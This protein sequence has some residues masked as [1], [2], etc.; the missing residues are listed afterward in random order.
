L[1][2][3]ADAVS[4]QSRTVRELRAKVSDEVNQALKAVRQPLVARTAAALRE[5]QEV[6]VEDAKVLSS[7]AYADV[8]SATVGSIGFAPVSAWGSDQAWLNERRAQGYSV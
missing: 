7:L 2:V 5:L 3:V 1:A 4:L 6:A 8:D